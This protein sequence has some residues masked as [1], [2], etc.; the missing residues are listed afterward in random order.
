MTPLPPPPPTA[1]R[2]LGAAALLMTTAVFLSRVIGFLR[3]AFVASRFG[4]GSE[5][6]AFF[7]AF[8]I[9]DWL[10]YLVAGGTLSISLLPIYA[11]HL[12]AGDEAAANRALSVV[13]TVIL[14]LVVLLIIVG[15]IFAAPLSRNH[16]PWL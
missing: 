7:A 9:P 2:R 11:R 6:D 4:A 10:N 16:R 1:L 3:E 5:T 15:E 12:A 8:T 13:A 14:T